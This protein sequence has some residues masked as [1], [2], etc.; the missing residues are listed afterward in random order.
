MKTQ[1][2]LMA[3][4]V[5]KDS[6]WPQAG[7]FCMVILP[8]LQ[9]GTQVRGYELTPLVSWKGRFSYSSWDAGV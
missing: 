6:C 2:P 3:Q 7:Q 4:P 9:V 5:P 1:L 8:A